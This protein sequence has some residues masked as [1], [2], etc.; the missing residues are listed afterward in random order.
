MLAS[1]TGADW[2]GVWVQDDKAKTIGGLGVFRHRGAETTRLETFVDA[3]FAFALTLLVISFDAVPQSYDE[4]VNALRAIPAFLF[5]FL[6]LMMFWTAHHNWSKRYGLDTTASILISMALIFIIMIYVYPLRAMATAAVSAITNGWLETEF[7]IRTEA[8]ARG[9][10][11]VY[12]TG[13][14]LANLC[15]IALNAHAY[16]LR[17]TL[18]L[19]PEEIFM[20]INEIVAWTLVAAV[21]LL[22][23]VLTFVVKGPWV[24]L[25][26]WV[27]ALLAIIMPTFGM[28]TS[29]RFERRFGG[30][31]A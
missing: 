6:I 29:R 2:R 30:N 27:Y 9:L 21:G 19:A 15:L 13:F 8:E 25:C 23:L 14:I 20:T 16:R 11:R 22:S 26:G 7:L 31:A 24:G 3:A 28:L 17:D 1:R 18:S 10:F 12:S 5:G 4:L